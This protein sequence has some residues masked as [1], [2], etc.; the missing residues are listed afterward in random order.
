MTAGNIAC[1][2][3]SGQKGRA[4]QNRN[5][6]TLNA[7]RGVAAICV[8]IYHAKTLLGLQ[9]IPHG[10]L[11]VDLFFALS[12]FVIAHAYDARMQAGMGAWSFTKT[13]LIRFYPLFLLGLLIGLLYELA[14]IATHNHFALSPAP[15]VT[16][17]VT[18]AVFLPWVTEHGDYNLFALNVPAWSL[19]FELLINIA[20]ALLYRKLSRTVLLASVIIAG[21]VLVDCSS[22]AG[23]T[24]LGARV[25]DLFGP[26]IPGGVARTVFSFSIGL[27]LYRMH[28]RVFRIPAP[29]ILLLVALALLMPTTIG[30]VYDLAF[31][32]VISP[33]LVLLGAAVEPGRAAE[34]VFRHLG[35]M[36]FAMYAIHRPIIVFAKAV[37]NSVHVPGSVLTVGAI[38]VIVMLSL[39]LDRFYDRPV[40]GW[41]T[42]RFNPRVRVDPAAVA[43]P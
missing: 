35:I 16:T 5:Y 28:L 1:E 43:A 39:T 29:V 12:G 14:L 22:V 24:D 37:G 20:Y 2:D 27:L 42:R 4:L 6:E 36:S 38:T 40:R 23:S 34:P 17:L 13:R 21:L 7:I 10:Y 19:L 32:F 18:S 30:P 41:L 9:L 33:L 8:M 26:N 3:H 31:I 15:L 25:P 11:A